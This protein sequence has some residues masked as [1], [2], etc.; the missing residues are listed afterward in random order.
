MPQDLCYNVNMSAIDPGSSQY[1][2]YPPTMI[3][4][5]VASYLDMADIPPAV[6]QLGLEVV[7]GPAELT[8]IVGISY[9]LAYIVHNA[10][11]NEVT[12]VI[13]GTN[14]VSLGSWWDE[15]FQIGT[16]VPF[17]KYAPHAKGNPQISQGTANGIDY[18]LSLQDPTTNQ[19]MVAFLL[20]WYTQGPPPSAVYVTGHSLGGAL[21]PPMVAILNDAIFDGGPITDMAWWTFAGPTSGDESFANYFE[22]LWPF[23]FP[24]RYHNTLDIAPFCWWSEDDVENIYVPNDLYWGLPESAGIELLFYSAEGISYTQPAADVTLQGTFNDDWLPDYLWT[25]QAAD[26]HSSDTYQTLVNAMYPTAGGRTIA[27]PTRQR[28]DATSSPR[29]RTTVELAD[30]PPINKPGS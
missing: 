20:N 10:A 28:R 22:A 19:Q 13:R 24:G 8:D 27:G 6:Q 15:D 14:M 25:V 11:T 18:L 1:A 5:C 16:L 29:G 17:K 4:L 26:Q 21:T 9:S 3:A 23:Q 7:W 12:V 30:F 2:S